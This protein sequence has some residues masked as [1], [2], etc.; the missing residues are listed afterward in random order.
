MGMIKKHRGVYMDLSVY[1][2]E[3]LKALRDSI[4]DELK[5]RTATARK[6]AKDE[7]VE[8]EEKYTGNVNDGDVVSFLYNRETLTLPVDRAN[9]KTLTVTIN[10]KKRYVK[11]ENV[12][13]VVERAPEKPAEEP[14]AEAVGE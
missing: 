4:A 2:V 10:G 1:S 9:A 8:R 11:Y 12:L 7:K 5:T 3:E 13:D 6:Q 14:T